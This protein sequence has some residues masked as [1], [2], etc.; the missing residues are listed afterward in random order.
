MKINLI[1][2]DSRKVKDTYYLSNG[3][4]RTSVCYVKI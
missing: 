4:I 2:G 1:H 3:K